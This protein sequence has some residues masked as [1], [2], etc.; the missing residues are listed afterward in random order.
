MLLDQMAQRYSVKPSDLANSNVEDLC[1]DI[2]VFRR[3]I[4]KEA[5]R[6]AKRAAEQKL[7]SKYRSYRVPST[8]PVHK[9]TIRRP[10]RY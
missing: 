3:A 9:K 1:F 7:D 6:D 10:R 2:F 5:K 8:P 4:E